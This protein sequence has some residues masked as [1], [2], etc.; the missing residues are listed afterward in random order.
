[1]KYLPTKEY[2]SGMIVDGCYSFAVVKMDDSAKVFINNSELEIDT[3]YDKNW[4]FVKVV[5]DDKTFRF[6]G[7]TQH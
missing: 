7:K 5:E 6:Y 3:R 4:E 1:M 2:H